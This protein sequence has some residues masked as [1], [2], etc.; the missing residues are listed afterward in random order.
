[1]HCPGWK[2]LLLHRNDQ[3]QTHAPAPPN[4][5]EVVGWGRLQKTCTEIAEY[6]STYVSTQYCTHK[7][8]RMSWQLAVWDVWDQVQEFGEMS[9]EMLLSDFCSN[10]CYNFPTGPTV[11]LKTQQVRNNQETRMT[12]L[13][14]RHS[15]STCREWD[16]CPSWISRAFSKWSLSCAASPQRPYLGWLV[17]DQLVW[18]RQLRIERLVQQLTKSGKKSQLPIWLYLTSR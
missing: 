6:V 11:A 3:G 8:Q 13:Q 12:S 4:T 7:T 9:S 2:G 14:S 15:E 1:M 5:G 18:S 16:M 17:G 10:V